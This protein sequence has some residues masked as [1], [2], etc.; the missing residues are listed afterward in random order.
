M[1]SR[2]L[3]EDLRHTLDK[4]SLAERERLADSTILLTGCA[5]FIGYYLMNFFAE[6]KGELHI[7]KIIALDNFLLGK[8]AWLRRYESDADFDIQKFDVAR[9]NIA[10]VPRAETAD[11]I[12][13]MA[14]VASPTF[15]R[16]YPI[17]TLDAN[18]WGL[19]HLLD[20]YRDK[21]I[22]GMLF[23]SSS[24]TY[25]DPDEKHIPTAESYAGNVSFTGPRSC[26]DESKR[27]G[28]TI[29]MLYHQQ[30]NL[31]IGVVR[32]FNNY[33]P[34][35]R[36]GDKRVPADFAQAVLRGEDIAVLSDGTPTRTFCHIADA[37]VGYLKVLLLGSYDFFNIGIESPEISVKT[38]ADIY[39]EAGRDLLGYGGKVI[40]AKAAE[41]N[42]LVNNP[43]RRCP[44]IKKARRILHYAPD[45]EVRDGVTRF[46]RF[47]Q[48]SPQEEYQW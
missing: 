45:I 27:F 7:R 16:R 32:P 5:G 22:K 30:Y 43:Q 4:L 35:M 17:E 21:A 44:D 47:L 14:S 1:I 29:C 11:Y 40:L 6:F 12:I 13:H 26:Y 41:K 19:R 39:A 37:A 23:F 28:E 46:L 33:G 42:Y 3:H 25:G 31:P 18:I 9:D 38:L 10:A 34:G 20:F 8:P 15:Y 24:E 48:E 2:Q 36:L